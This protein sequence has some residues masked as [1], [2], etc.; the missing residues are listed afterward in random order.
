MGSRL[1]HRRDEWSGRVVI[2]VPHLI[3]YKIFIDLNSG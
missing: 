1:L 2:I 3:H